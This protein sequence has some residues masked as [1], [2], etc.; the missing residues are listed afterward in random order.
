MSNVEV[1]IAVAF[2]CFIW[3]LLVHMWL[4]KLEETRVWNR[5]RVLERRAKRDTSENKK[6]S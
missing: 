3:F 4:Y 1:L 2:V 5:K 6:D